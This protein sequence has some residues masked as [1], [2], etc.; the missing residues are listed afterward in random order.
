MGN[1]N[2]TK[3]AE[4]SGVVKKYTLLEKHT[5]AADKGSVLGEKH[6]INA[7][8]VVIPLYSACDSFL[9]YV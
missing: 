3:K 7:L 8:S 4:D 2:E 9:Q 5:G 6:G 1:E